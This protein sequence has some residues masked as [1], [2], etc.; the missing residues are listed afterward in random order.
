MLW[1]PEPR[2]Q[3][4]DDFRVS[5]SKC[6]SDLLIPWLTVRTP[7]E[8]DLL[9]SRNSPWLSPC[10]ISLVFSVFPVFPVLTNLC[11]LCCS[12]SKMV[13]T[14][15]QAAFNHAMFSVGNVLSALFHL[16]PIHLCSLSFCIFIPMK[17]P[18][19]GSRLH[20]ELSSPVCS[21]STRDCMHN[22]EMIDL[23]VFPSLHTT[24]F[25]G[26]RS[27]SYSLVYIQPFA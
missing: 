18:P 6:S 26:M 23:Q 1:F 12:A 9:K 15:Y 8:K 22:V 10:F 13:F 7:L 21:R 20:T 19:G 3:G 16:I 11:I 14:I 17:P 5:Y 25:S 4:N 27:L 24:R 2:T